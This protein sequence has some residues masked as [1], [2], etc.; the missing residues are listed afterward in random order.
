MIRFRAGKKS[1]SEDKAPSRVHW[2]D[3][4]CSI[5]ANDKKA[6]GDRSPIK[7]IAELFPWLQVRQLGH[8]LSSRMDVQFLVD[9][10][11]VGIHCGY[12]DTQGLGYFLVKI[13]TRQEFQ[14]LA[15]AR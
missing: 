15:F 9:A 11:D 1:F 5:E 7:S 2:N 12:A 3:I 6:P 14:N 4:K 8:R 13:T 10:A